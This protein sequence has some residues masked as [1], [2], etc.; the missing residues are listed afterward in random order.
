MRIKDVG[1]T[2]FSIEFGSNA[3]V[4]GL[5]AAIR[6]SRPVAG[7]IELVPSLG[8]LLVCFD[9]LA[10]S[11]AEIEAR[12]VA[13]AADAG[14]GAIAEGRLWRIPVRYDGPD[15]EPVARACGLSPQEV[16]V[17]HAG[18]TYEVRMLGFMPGFA[19]MGGVPELLR[20]PRRAEPRVKVPAG[21]VAIADDMTA[22]YPWD[23]PGGWHLL[24]R[25]SVNLFDQNREPPALLAAGDRVEFIAE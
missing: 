3:E 18:V 24:G 15:L 17:L 4:V 13:L 14:P 19:Y 10:T 23:S 5:R 25:S 2:A 7:L 16:V 1:D 6:R 22:I 20:L 8:S 11:R 9:P 12:I 21:S